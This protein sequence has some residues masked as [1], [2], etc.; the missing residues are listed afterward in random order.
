MSIKLKDALFESNNNEIHKIFENQESTAEDNIQS[1]SRP[2]LQMVK[3]TITSVIKTQIPDLK[4]FNPEDVK[5]LFGVINYQELNKVSG[6]PVKGIKIDPMNIKGEE[7]EGLK[8]T[9]FKAY[10]SHQV[11]P[12]FLTN[13]QM[14][15][16]GGTKGSEEF[17]AVFYIPAVLVPIMSKNLPLHQILFKIQNPPKGKTAVH[18]SLDSIHC[19]LINAEEKE[20]IKGEF[21]KNQSSFSVLK[22]VE[23]LQDKRQAGLKQSEKVGGNQQQPQKTPAKPEQPVQKQ[24]KEESISYHSLNKDFIHENY[25]LKDLLSEDFGSVGKWFS[26]FTKGLTGEKDE[27][28][29]EIY[30]GPAST[31]TFVSMTDTDEEDT[32]KTEYKDGQAKKATA[33]TNK[34]I[35][36]LK[37]AGVFVFGSKYVDDV[38]ISAFDDN[39]ANDSNNITVNYDKDYLQSY[40]KNTGKDSSNVA[41]H[42]CDRDGTIN[43]DKFIDALPEVIIKSNELINVNKKATASYNLDHKSEFIISLQRQ[44]G[45]FRSPALGIKRSFDITSDAIMKMFDFKLEPS[46]KD[47]NTQFRIFTGSTA[48]LDSIFLKLAS[49]DVADNVKRLVKRVNDVYMKK[50]SKVNEKEYAAAEVYKSVVTALFDTDSIANK[51]INLSTSFNKLDTILDPDTI[52]QGAVGQGSQKSATAK[53][54][55]GLDL[56]DAIENLNKRYT[57]Y[58]LR[59]HRDTFKDESAIKSNINKIIDELFYPSIHKFNENNTDKKFAYITFLGDDIS[60]STTQ[61]ECEEK[62]VNLYNFPNRK[63]LLAVIYEIREEFILELDSGGDFTEIANYY[64]TGKDFVR[65]IIDIFISALKGNAEHVPMSGK[66]KASV[67]SKGAKKELVTSLKKAIDFQFEKVS[68]IMTKKLNHASSELP[69]AK[70]VYDEIMKALEEDDM[71]TVDLDQM[72]QNQTKDENISSLINLNKILRLM[73][74]DKADLT[75]FIDKMD[76]ETFDKDIEQVIIK[77]V[78]KALQGILG[79]TSSI[80]DHYEIKNKNLLSEIYLNEKSGVQKAGEYASTAQPWLLAAKV[81]VV[82]YTGINFPALTSILLVLGIWKSIYQTKNKRKL[83]RTAKK[84]PEMF[85]EEVIRYAAPLVLAAAR[86][87]ISSTYINTLFVYEDMLKENGITLKRSSESL[88]NMHNSFKQSQATSDKKKNLN[89]V[90]QK[91]YGDIIDNAYKFVDQSPLGKYINQSSIE[92]MLV[93]SIFA[94]VDNPRNKFAKLIDFL[95][96]EKELQLDHHTNFAYKLGLSYLLK[97][98][99]DSST[100]EVPKDIQVFEINK[101]RKQLAQIITDE[102][103][104]LSFKT[105]IMK[106]IN[107]ELEKNYD[108][109]NIS[110]GFFKKKEGKKKAVLYLHK[111]LNRVLGFTKKETN[112]FLKDNEFLFEGFVSLNDVELML[113]NMSLSRLLNEDASDEDE[114]SASGE[115]VDKPLEVKFDAES[116]RLAMKYQSNSGDVKYQILDTKED[117]IK[118]VGKTSEYVE[119]KLTAREL[120]REEGGVYKLIFPRVGAGEIE[121]EIDPEKLLD[122]DGNPFEMGD[123]GYDLKNAR[124]PTYHAIKGKHYISYTENPSDAITDSVDNDQLSTYLNLS[125]KK[126]EYFSEELGGSFKVEK[127]LGKKI[128]TKDYKSVDEAEYEKFSGDAITDQ[129]EIFQKQMDLA[130]LKRI[131]TD[132]YSIYKGMVI[133]NE[134]LDA[135]GASYSDGIVTDDI[136][137]Q[138]ESYAADDGVF[139]LNQNGKSLLPVRI[140]DSGEIKFDPQSATIKDIKSLAQKDMPQGFKLSTSVPPSATE[141]YSAPMSSEA[142][143]SNNEEIS[144]ASESNVT[145]DDVATDDVATDDVATDDADAATPDQAPDDQATPDQATPDQATPDDADAAD[146]AT[147]DQ[148][149]D[150]VATDDQATPDQAT[151]AAPDDV[152]AAADFGNLGNNEL[153]QTDYAKLTATQKTDFDSELTKRI[154]RLTDENDPDDAGILQK[155]NDKKTEIG[156]GGK[157][158]VLPSAGDKSDIDYDLGT[159]NLYLL[160][161]KLLA[162][163]WPVLNPKKFN[164]REISSAL[165]KTNFAALPAVAFADIIC[166]TVLKYKKE[167]G[168]LGI[169]VRGNLEKVSSVGGDAAG[170]VED[171]VASNVLMNKIKQSPAFKKLKGPEKDNISDEMIISA[172]EDDL[173]RICAGMMKKYDKQR[174]KEI[175]KAG[176][177]EVYAKARSG[178]FFG[179]I[180]SKSP[181]SVINRISGDD[182]IAGRKSALRKATA[183]EVNSLAS[184]IVS[185]VK[186]VKGIED[187]NVENRFIM[188][189][190]SNLLFEDLELDVNPKGKNQITAKRLQSILQSTGALV[191]GSELDPASKEFKNAENFLIGTMAGFVEQNFGV[192]VQGI[193]NFKKLNLAEVEAE[194]IVNKEAKQGEVASREIEAIVDGSGVPQSSNSQFDINQFVSLLNHCG[195]DPM[196]AFVM[197]MINNPQIGQKLQ[198]IQKTGGSIKDAAK[199]VAK[200]EPQLSEI[201]R[202]IETAIKTGRDN[203]PKMSKATVKK[204][205]N[206]LL[207][208]PLDNAYLIDKVSYKFDIKIDKQ[209]FVSKLKNY[210]KITESND[211]K[212]NNSQASSI[213]TFIRNEIISW[214]G[215]Y[216][217]KDEYISLGRLFVPYYIERLSEKLCDANNSLSQNQINNVLQRVGLKNQISS[218]SSDGLDTMFASVVNNCGDKFKYNDDATAQNEFEFE[219]DDELDNF[220]KEY[221]AEKSK[222]INSMEKIKIVESKKIGLKQK[223][224][225]GERRLVNK[226]L[227]ESEELQNIYKSIWNLR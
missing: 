83:A 176:D 45:L 15:S 72:L 218:F 108:A 184:A 220:K 210:F 194:M 212:D 21:L 78:T 55:K 58:S 26:D 16:L 148:A 162:L 179:F 178:G 62:N 137:D 117:G 28:K 147:P 164:V 112:K 7:E 128:N 120:T 94:D 197:M 170:V 39:I 69:E 139:T 31:Y 203:L 173:A 195:G 82:W 75:A 57:Y 87:A 65:K 208:K 111:V 104:T 123:G 134:V 80:L 25:D 180:K 38:V 34:T 73:K 125:N 81:G 141:D 215:I 35:N 119:G 200:E 140:E 187:L 222:A 76:S 166:Q 44:K 98:A 107:S 49:Q 201:D 225:S 100:K 89:P 207:T 95:Q 155:L 6:K 223:V 77:L 156:G 221:N 23:K 227:K 159:F 33:S 70:K 71:I 130:I 47:V 186:D 97:E 64:G 48:N 145:P 37:T 86:A 109:A 84:Q 154:E 14:E 163:A 103:G 54:R 165:E 138:I 151:P 91:M 213:D 113:E 136:E 144:K 24:K 152:D 46:E 102:F 188:G 202:E 193:D 17:E 36:N 66:Q 116:G 171:Q 192:K 30:K 206:T 158:E 67:E 59:K 68:P 27:E 11:A 126:P 13:K 135:D 88:V 52:S 124:M 160:A 216:C 204:V 22:Q 196:L 224:L 5:S 20:A 115:N 29:P 61:K 167:L 19:Q 133:K 199:V 211:N 143:K 56:Q 53:D 214:G 157:E 219:S 60:N 129:T 51:S 43:V 226:I 174:Y 63:N 150:D 181:A 182:V 114:W 122:T 32:D 92:N 209:S 90:G 121:V 110:F 183:E 142:I 189:S 1:L 74:K 161:T 4:Q 85:G 127:T 205:Y 217:I 131:D 198:Q 169:D 106:A 177:K 101:L 146:A 18:L 132:Q 40:V 9:D 118:A 172:I 8:P 96:K 190:L 99:E 12:L 3:R 105:D 153:V 185:L 2:A 79:T 41:S 191:Y 93:K 42:I 175:N 10:A 149:P 50:F 168:E